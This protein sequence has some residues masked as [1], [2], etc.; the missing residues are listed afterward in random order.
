M[1]DQDKTKEQIIEELIEIRHEV[2]KLKTL[3]NM[4][5]HA[6]ESLQE[7]EE[8]YRL[9]VENANEPILVAQDGL[10][11]FANAKAAEVVGYPISELT[12]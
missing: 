1:I 6:I 8:K 11:K 7:S 9:M 10:L 2:A 3:E 4:H 12:P 5:K